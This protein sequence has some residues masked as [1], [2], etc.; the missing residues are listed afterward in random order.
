MI[1]FTNLRTKA[2]A[3]VAMTAFSVGSVFGQPSH[4]STYFGGKAPADLTAPKMLLWNEQQPVQAPL[5]STNTDLAKGV[6]VT[7]SN[8]QNGTTFVPVNP[9]LPITTPAPSANPA[10]A[11]Y[12]V[13]GSGLNVFVGEDNRVAVSFDISTKYLTNVNDLQI[14]LD[15][16]TF[17]E[18]SNMDV[19]FDMKLSVYDLDGHLLKYNDIYK[20]AGV[21]PDVDWAYKRVS[22]YPYAGWHWEHYPYLDGYDEEDMSLYIDNV[23]DTSWGSE[24]G[25]LK[26]FQTANDLIEDHKF[27]EKSLDNKII[28][29]TLISDR[30]VGE[31]TDHF[32]AAL[33]VKS[34][35][36]SSDVPSLTIKRAGNTNVINAGMGYE[37]TPTVNT[38][39]TIAQKGLS[40]ED[41]DA[42]VNLFAP[43]GFKITNTLPSPASSGSQL[44]VAVVDGQVELV[45]QALAYYYF[46][47]QTIGTFTGPFEAEA[48]SFI[49]ANDALSPIQSLTATS[50][51][52]NGNS[53]PVLAL[54]KTQLTFESTFHNQSI[55]VSGYNI[56]LVN[57]DKLKFRG[58]YAEDQDDSNIAEVGVNNYFKVGDLGVIVPDGYSTAKIVVDYDEWRNNVDLI[59]IF[60]NIRVSHHYYVPNA[61]ENSPTTFTGRRTEHGIAPFP[62]VTVIGDVAAVWFEYEGNVDG[63]QKMMPV[64]DISTAFYAPYDENKIDQQFSR[65]KAFYL[66]G[67]KVKAN[68][69]DKALFRISLD[70]WMDSTDPICF[71]Y[72]VDDGATWLTAA[73]TSI[74]SVDLLTQADEENFQLNGKKILVKFRPVS[75]E[76]FKVHEN[77]K[78]FHN[79]NPLYKWE[80]PYN[81]LKVKQINEESLCGTSAIIFGDT[82]ADLENSLHEWNP[83]EVMQNSIV[84]YNHALLTK[85]DFRKD[86]GNT[87]LGDCGQ[88]SNPLKEGK[89]V[90]TGYN[91][92][93]TVNIINIKDANKAFKVTVV[94]EE[95]YGTVGADGLSIKPNMYGEVMATVNV[96]FD[97]TE[98]INVRNVNDVF[99]VGY[100]GRTVEGSKCWWDPEFDYVSILEEDMFEGHPVHDL[101]L[102]P[103]YH[104][105]SAIVCG[106]VYDPE[107]SDVDIRALSANINGT[108]SVMFTFSATDLDKTR[109][110]VTLS[111]G[112]ANTP[113]TLSDAVL[114]INQEGNASG[115]IKL[116][117]APKVANM[118]AG[119][120]FL[121]Y[122]YGTCTNEVDSSDIVGT[123]K[124]AQP[125][126]G[127]M[128]PG[129]IQGDRVDLRITPAV[130]GPN[131][132]IG[133]GVMEYNIKSSSIFMSEVFAEGNV[134]HIELFNGTGEFLNDDIL[135]VGSPNYYLEVYEGA[136]KVATKVLGA[137]DSALWE[138]YGIEIKTV[139]FTM[140]NS[141]NHKIVLKQG[142]I[143][144]DV[145]EF[146]GD[147]S[148]MSRKDNL[149]PLAYK[150]STFNE[151]DWT[152]LGGWRTSLNATQQ[153]PV[154]AKMFHDTYEGA[155]FVQSFN[156][157]SVEQQYYGF[158]KGVSVSK[159]KKGVTYTAYAQTL[160]ECPTYMDVVGHARLFSVP[161]SDSDRVTGLPMEGVTF[162]YFTGIDQV[163]V[164]KNIYAANGKIYV[165]GATEGVTI[166]NALGMQVKAA[167]I[168]EAAAGIEVANGIYM[169][170]SGD[171]TAK[172]LVNK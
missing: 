143:V 104:Y 170:K 159:L 15:A 38:K 155:G 78:F 129:D 46:A 9:A 153:R 105:A 131:Y 73:Q 111:L 4:T 8:S 36:I 6:R 56:P 112:E 7:F 31:T 89:F 120:N 49:N 141:K 106:R 2:L 123:T 76:Y 115:T 130:G 107:F 149:D 122:T 67:A 126:F 47:P 135:E 172:V 1:K 22:N 26:L 127:E 92:T 68:A 121:M 51:I 52:V 165:A 150:T 81:L 34:M 83:I 30:P 80:P 13:N 41:L 140:D 142:Q 50:E 75:E 87:Y 33:V 40:L 108:D 166:F 136:T 65:T 37:T 48:Y 158:V 24:N 128:L 17:G 156:S 162:G 164:A 45:D 95:G 60:H 133:I 58:G 63:V 18:T 88:Q 53:V 72:S 161:C 27:I 124:V 79:D 55:G 137:A 134:M 119:S 138:P 44:K 110:T 70:R 167:S 32:P 91:L 69:D 147:H 118:C 100:D 23:Y 66:K 86:Y 25:T 103:R 97:P 14:L 64:G 90:V 85:S 168:E 82:R 12:W 157:L 61:F 116:K 113:F 171:K 5:N 125:T 163:E 148:H 160:E 102:Y 11:S 145:Y 146:T 169:V 71:Y 98:K 94:P 39:L 57:N 84:L 93:D 144:L 109:K 28:R 59:T 21:T 62:Q 114:D 29:V 117:F 151:S 42:V 132:K 43:E 74:I 35:T 154:Y 54:D 152:V 20:G 101:F 139:N 16:N 3:L 19:K 96:L 10:S 77:T 99:N